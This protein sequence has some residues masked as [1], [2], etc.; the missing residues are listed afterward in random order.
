MS[1]QAGITLMG[2]FSIAQKLG[3]AALG[4]MAAIAAIV[5]YTYFSVDAHR[6][7][8]EV[9]DLAGRQRML[10]QSA[11][12]EVLLN[13]AGM[14]SSPDQTLRAF[15]QTLEA[16][17]NGGLAPDNLSTGTTIL[18]SPVSVPDAQTSYARQKGLLQDFRSLANA[19][20]AL[21]ANDPR[22]QA[23]LA[24]LMQSSQSLSAAANDF[25]QSVDTHSDSKLGIVMRNDILLGLLASLAAIFMTLAIGRNIVRPLKACVERSHDIAV[26][27]LK[28]D[29]LS[30]TSEDEIGVLSASFNSMLDSLRDIA[31]R[32]RMVTENLNASAAEIFATT[33]EQA[34]A[35]RQQAAAVQQITATVEEI[36]QSGK[37]VAERAKH[38]SGSAQSMANASNVGLQAVESIVKAM[39]GIRHQ[40]GSVADNIVTL[41]ERTQAIGEIIATVT[42]IA[43]QSNLVALNAAIE[44]ADARE[45]GR[46]FAVVANEIKNLADQAKDATR[47]VRN[48]LE[49]IQRGINTSV[50]LTEEA[51]KRVEYG[52]EKVTVADDAIRKM[53]ANVAESANAFQQ[54]GGATNQ[55][56]IGFEQVVQALQEIRQASQQTA[57]STG[58]LEA[59]AGGF[60]SLSQQLRDVVEKYRV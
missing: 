2:K 14:Q 43:E 30:V 51:M 27:N 32:T 18:L 40:A 42:D 45:D 26:G 57:S 53:T 47:R 37:Q 33:K 55:Q 15:E 11:M 29:Y 8:G 44:A 10:V 46:R 13:S 54:I 48:I 24:E 41:S 25:V 21:P 19:F 12:K 35:T 49:E 5:G 38:V 22:R 60:N 23:K 6:W 9:I 3:F 1:G 59:A 36:N 50:L 7:D 17:V 56:Q 58:Q 31:S 4:G 28:V 52:R 16:L 39:E 34:A 20:I